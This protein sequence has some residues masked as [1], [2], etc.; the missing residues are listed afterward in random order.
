MIE[1]GEEIKWE[2]L[3]SAASIFLTTSEG[4]SEQE[5]EVEILYLRV[6]GGNIP[7]LMLKSLLFFCSYSHSL[8]D[9]CFTGKNGKESQFYWHS[10]KSQLPSTNRIVN[11]AIKQ[12]YDRKDGSLKTCKVLLC[13]KIMDWSTNQT[14]VLCRFI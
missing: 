12:W 8:E 10:E 4:P 9:N 14:Y 6:Q 11:F 5:I 2:R 1:L 7:D 3:W 13:F